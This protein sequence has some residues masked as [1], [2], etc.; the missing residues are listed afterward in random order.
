MDIRIKKT[1]QAVFRSFTELLYMKPYS[2]ITIQEILDHSKIGRSTFYAHFHTKE[3]LLRSLCSDILI[4]SSDSD[5]NMQRRVSKETAAIIPEF[6]KLI[7]SILYHIQSKNFELK[8]I[9]NNECR[10]LFLTFFNE[11]LSIMLE[12]LTDYF[13]YNIPKEFLLSY[14]VN[15]LSECVFWW[16]Q[17]AQYS[18]EDICG[19]FFS[20]NSEWN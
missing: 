12:P 18:C 15:S 7:R 13:P 17:H 14:L 3:D 1:Q 19:Y 10:P 8:A 2:Q 16:M 11:Q 6:N 5:I 4:L 9:A 20:L